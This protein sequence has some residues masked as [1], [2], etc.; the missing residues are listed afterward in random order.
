[1]LIQI[2]I[3]H[4]WKSF[5]RNARW[6]RNLL[7][8]ILLAILVFFILSMLS[9]LGYNIDK[10]LLELGGN[11]IATFNSFLIP[12]LFID[13]FLRFIFQSSPSVYFIPYLRFR[14]QHTKLVTLM[15]FRSLWSFFNIIPW[16]L[17]IPFII[18]ILFKESG[19][20]TA[21]PYFFAIFLLILINNFLTSVIQFLIRKRKIFYFIPLCI[22]ILLF[23]LPRI[24]VSIKISSI[25][26]GNQITEF[27]FFI[28]VSLLT[29][30]VFIISLLRYLLL[31]GFYVDEPSYKNLP[32]GLF[33]SPINLN[34][35]SK[36]G[37]AGNYLSLEIKLILRNKRP[38]QTISIYPV[39]PI[40]F[41]VSLLNNNVNT[42]FT[43]L[44]LTFSYGLLSVLYGQYIFS[45]ESTF[46]DLIMTKKINFCEY[47]KAKY[48]L[49]ILF[50]IVIFTLLIPLF[51]LFFRTHII[52]LFS[53]FIF[54]IG[55]VN[56]I[57]LLNGV[58]NDGRINLNE[59][60]FFNYQGLNSNQLFLPIIVFGI[61]VG[62]YTF[63]N[64]LTNSLL[65][66]ILLMVI[67][68]IFLIFHNWW[69]KNI[70]LQIFKKRK[71]KN[72]EGFRKLMN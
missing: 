38:K 12:Y 43:L 65:A 29:V 57:V 20:K 28:F 21:I 55:T 13:L 63:I 47:I 26:L 15:I 71:Y 52:C 10:I 25:F 39:L 70:I 51:L 41:I 56:F 40:F 60:F 7:S 6:R 58:F 24:G 32:K 54:S 27:S 1:M 50:T 46:F 69:I 31:S 2:F 64:L 23:I 17:V 4:Q 68:V 66:N 35:F 30:L 72:L 62:L 53:M 5:I 19:L 3:Y 22:A 61:P 11:P 33:L 59:S 37:M 34:L 67:G 8:N 44:L 48:Y 45:W 18:K 36:P 14:L 16:F 9:I 42:F 49:M